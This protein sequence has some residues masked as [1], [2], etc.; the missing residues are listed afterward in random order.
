MRKQDT[1]Y[2]TLLEDFARGRFEFGQPLLVREI[3]AGTGASKQPIMAALKQLETDGFVH[4]TAQVGCQ[5]VSPDTQAI[6]DF[7]VMFSRMEGVM[8]EFA[9][10][11]HTDTELLQLEAINVQIGKLPIRHSGSGERYRSLNREFHTVIHRMARSPALHAQL[12]TCW[13]LSDFY[14]ARHTPFV[15]H[16]REAANE[17]NSIIAALKTRKP[18]RARQAMEEHILSF[19]LKVIAKRDE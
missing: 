17:H 10:T 5:V 19:R 8:A 2:Q 15:R 9:A 18:P 16:L 11:R 14:I 1:V 7:F 13:A 12:V 3:A 6:A 4:I